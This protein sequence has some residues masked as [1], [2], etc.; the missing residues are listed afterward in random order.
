MQT[1]LVVCVAW[2]VVMAI[3]LIAWTYRFRVKEI[4]AFADPSDNSLSDYLSTVRFESDPS[5][6][7]AIKANK[8]KTEYKIKNVAKHRANL[9]SQLPPH[10]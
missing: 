2:S 5:V 8:P 3:S 7:A 6:V 4:D 1:V 9:P 10:V